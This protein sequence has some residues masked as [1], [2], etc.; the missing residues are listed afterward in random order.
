MIATKGKKALP[1]SVV[2]FE[3]L[4]CLYLFKTIRSPWE[5]VE[6]KITVESEQNSKLLFPREGAAIGRKGSFYRSNC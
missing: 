6:K 5:M 2:L 1:G 4:W 3:N